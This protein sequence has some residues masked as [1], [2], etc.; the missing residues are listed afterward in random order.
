MWGYSSKWKAKERTQKGSI[1][2]VKGC[3]MNMC[4]KLTALAKC[5]G[6]WYMDW[7][8]HCIGITCGDPAFS[9]FPRAF[10]LVLFSFFGF[11]YRDQTHDLACTC[12]AVSFFSVT[13]GPVSCSVSYSFISEFSCFSWELFISENRYNSKHHVKFVIWLVF[14]E[15]CLVS[16]WVFHVFLMLS[17][18]HIWNIT[19]HWIYIIINSY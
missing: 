5:Y 16:W 15:K 13:F 8:I 17:I 18:F 3:F 6:S 10:F 1:F 12:L 2:C 9:R 7:D 4:V 11:W 14:I 19:T